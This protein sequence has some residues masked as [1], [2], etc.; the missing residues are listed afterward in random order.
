MRTRFRRTLPPLLI[1]AFGYAT[2]TPDPPM[3]QSLPAAAFGRTPEV[4]NVV[5]SPSGTLLAW[6]AGDDQN[7][8]VT[9]FDVVQQRNARLVSVGNNYKL[10]DLIW[11]DDKTLLLYVSRVMTLKGEPRFEFFRTLAVDVSGGAARTLLMEDG[12][13]DLVSG[14][15]L[16]AWNVTKP[17]TVIMATYDYAQTAHKEAIGSRLVGGRRDDGWVYSL[18]EVNLDSGK[19]RRVEAGTPYSTD[20]IVNHD[21]NAIARCDWQADQSLFRIMVRDGLGWRELLRRT[22]GENL[23]VSG[24]SEDGSGL[25][26]LGA[27]GQPRKKLWLLPLDGS[28]PKVL[29]ED[30]NYDVTSVIRDRFSQATIGVTLGGLESPLRWLDHKAELRQKGL[31]RSFPSQSVETYGRSVDNQ[32]V[33]VRVSNSSH[34]AIYYLVD[35]SKKTADIAGEEYPG[36]TGAMLGEVRSITYKA[37]DGY[38]VPAYL[39]IP[40]G[41]TRSNLPLVVMPHGGPASR[42]Q[43]DF[44]WWSQ[45]LASRGYAVLRPQFRGSTGFGEAHRIAGER[46]WGKRMQDD[47]TDGIKAMVEQSVVDPARI[48]IVGAS[49]GGYAALAGAAFTPDLYACAVSVGGVADLPMMLGNVKKRSGSDSDSLAYW[50]E[51]IGSPYDTDVIAKSPARSAANV[52]APILLIHGVEDT[53]V[54]IAQAE[55]MFRALQAESK[56]VSFIRLDGEDHWLSRSAMRIRLLQ[57]IE[58][59]LA[60]YLPVRTDVGK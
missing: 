3:T 38:E 23:A 4:S 48:C 16:I 50:H 29:L 47:I 49:Y 33:L 19:G 18:F 22:D 35:F 40:P 44:D 53:V 8:I 45:F 60:K 56:S 54:P 20:W 1:L 46:Q 55:A 37:R 28:A 2:A 31:E 9:M 17:R 27:M 42:D 43:R 39:T 30:A 51:H 36:L 58:T 10:R 13:R 32:R 12:N 11:A 25:I 26:A 57:E 14:S 59:F 34:P 15:D 21:G 41:A 5:L 52:R 7:P 24:M 6:V